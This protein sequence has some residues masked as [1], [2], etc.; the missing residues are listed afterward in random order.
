MKRLFLFVLISYVITTVKFVYAENITPNPEILIDEMSVAT[1]Q[2][3][4]D[5]I[6]IYRHDKQ[7]DT[8]RIIHKKNR[9]GDIYE[10]L[11]SLTGNAREVIREKD[12]VKYFFPKNKIA[13]VEKNRL[14]Q[15][16]SSYIPDPIQSI[17]EFYNFDIVGDGR[18]AGLDAW[19][20]NIKP[21]DRY[22]YGYQLWID[23]KSKLLLKS[24]L[25]NFQGV[26]LEY[27]MFTQIHILENISD[28]L[29]KSSF[30]SHNFT[31]INNIKNTANYENNSGRKWAASWMPGGF[32]ISEYSKDP[33]STSKIPVEHFIYTD[34]LASI[35]I[36]VEK[37]NQQHKKI[38]SRTTNFGGVNTYSTLNDGYQITAVGEVPKATVKL[39]ADSVQSSH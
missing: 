5:G 17:S 29:L 18:V 28:L 15:L 3:N 22:R 4:Y 31:W 36:F 13:I 1:N 33:M 21:T 12:Q 35:S 14:G 10:R 23:K 7:I 30:S 26:T 32:S 6:F 34:G 2:L 19:I 37:L 9:N 11:I 38:N 24:K 8:M 25:K 39:I 20:V 16:I 27:I